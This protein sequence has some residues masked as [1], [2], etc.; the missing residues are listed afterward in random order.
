MPPFLPAQRQQYCSLPN[1]GRSRHEQLCR[2]DA[3]QP[4]IRPD[5]TSRPIRSC[6]DC[7]LFWSGSARIGKTA[8]PSQKMRQTDATLGQLSDSDPPKSIDPRVVDA[9]GGDPVGE[10]APQTARP[11]APSRLG[12]IASSANGRSSR[13]SFFSTAAINRGSA[14]AARRFFSVSERLASSLLSER[15]GRSPRQHTRPAHRTG[16][17][18]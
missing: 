9:A 1:F 18:R 10:D 16:P 15:Y 6:M 2:K 7:R 8:I 12:E 5:M 13:S 14:P 17:T 4:S 3:R 11:E